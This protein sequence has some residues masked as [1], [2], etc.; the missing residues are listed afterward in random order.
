MGLL[1]V[2]V[3]QISGVR[4]SLC[5]LKIAA[6]LFIGEQLSVAQQVSLGV[7]GGGR[8]TGDFVNNYGNPSSE[9]RRYIVG[10]MVDVK[11]PLHLS[12]EFDALYRRFGFTDYTYAFGSVVTRERANS[13]EFPLIVKY[14]LPGPIH[15]FVGVGW[16]PRVVSGTDVSSGYYLSGIS[17]NPPADIY[18]YFFNS[19]SPTH[20]PET[21][22]L[23][24]SG[25]VDFNVG[26]LRISPQVRYVRWFSPFAFQGG[27]DGITGYSSNQNEVFG[28]LGL[29][30]HPK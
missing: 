30:W 18:T 1:G 26:H 10:P 22:G 27:D 13:W 9:S 8:I 5:A 4:L 7:V 28:V 16:A 12:V 6:I 20:Y 19:R 23:V 14:H 24:V 29:S 25:G 2:G 17:T 3:L 21:N 15:P 11:L